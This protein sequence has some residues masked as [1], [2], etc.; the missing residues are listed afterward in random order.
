MISAVYY[1]VYSTIVQACISLSAAAAVLPG[2][3]L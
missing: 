2:T 1:L 3:I